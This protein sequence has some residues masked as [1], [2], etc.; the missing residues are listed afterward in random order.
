VSP[1]A[2]IWPA[3]VLAFV[4][5][6]VAVWLN[7]LAVSWGRQG[8][9]R[10]VL[11]SVEQI[12][13]RLLE[14]RHSYTTPRFSIATRRV[15][16]R[17]LIRPIFTYHAN[18]DSPPFILTA[19]QAELRLNAEKDSLT[20]IMENGTI[21]FGEKVEGIFPD[22]YEYEVPLA[23]ASRKGVMDREPVGLRLAE[24]SPGRSPSSGRRSSDFSSR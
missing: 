19:E 9:H 11:H 16:G 22:R 21:E 24:K 5:S 23:A 1:M 17:K 15:D 8:A 10:V 14:T 2:L 6:L 12:A 13:Y 3:L 7:D 20:I 18:D 4:I